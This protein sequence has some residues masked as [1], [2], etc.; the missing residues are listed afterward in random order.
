MRVYPF[1]CPS[2]QHREGGERMS[3]TM[4][5]VGGGGN[6]RIFVVRGLRN[7]TRSTGTINV[8]TTVLDRLDG[9]FFS[10]DSTGVFTCKKAGTYYAHYYLKGSY[11]TSGAYTNVYGVLEKNGTQVSS[12]TTTDNTGKTTSVSLSLNVGDTVALKTRNAV[13]DGTNHNAFLVIADS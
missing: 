9:R 1:F 8:G 12:A 2:S 7:A 4:N 13:N 3:Q 5:M 6:P 11:N 10:Q